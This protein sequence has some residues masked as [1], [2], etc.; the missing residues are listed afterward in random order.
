MPRE[1][2]QELKVFIS[3]R[4]SVCGWSRVRKRY[5]RQGLLIETEGL[6]KAEDECLEDSE[7]RERRKEQDAARREV[8]DRRYVEQFAD[9]VRE[10]FPECPA[11][12][13][14][15]PA[16]LHSWSGRNSNRAC[17]TAQAARFASGSDVNEH[18][19]VQP[20]ACI[21]GRTSVR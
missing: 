20:F 16:L 10:L 8:L 6:Q 1:G 12:R 14:H 19:R 13:R 9:R 11:D 4:E 18:F 15:L 3:N 5:E 17:P 7:I 2:K 21:V